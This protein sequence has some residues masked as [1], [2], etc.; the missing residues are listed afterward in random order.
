MAKE[1]SF[2]EKS[3]LLSKQSKAGLARTN[4]NCHP[5]TKRQEAS[6]ETVKTYDNFINWPIHKQ[7]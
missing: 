2:G 6:S 3:V 7:V 5:E 1:N 4:G